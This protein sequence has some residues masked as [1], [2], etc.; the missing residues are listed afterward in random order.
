[1]VAVSIV[2]CQEFN[3]VHVL[4][5]ETVLLCLISCSPAAAAVADA[6]GVG[7]TVFSCRFRLSW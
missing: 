7:V 3:V 1:M 4:C 5:W 2:T 6:V